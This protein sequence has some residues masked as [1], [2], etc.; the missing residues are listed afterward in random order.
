M[1]FKFRE[2]AE[3]PSDTE[4][5]QPPALFTRAPVVRPLWRSICFTRHDSHGARRKRAQ[6]GLISMSWLIVL[7]AHF[8]GPPGADGLCVHA[9]PRTR[10]AIKSLLWLSAA[11]Q[12]LMNAVGWTFRWNTILRDL[13]FGKVTNYPVVDVQF[14]IK[15]R[16]GSVS[17]NV[18]PVCV[19]HI[20]WQ[21]WFLV[22]CVTANWT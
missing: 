12:V 13:D 5:H 15:T 20:W 9:A 17:P 10:R 6:T 2:C 14:F 3:S 11:R 21:N 19:E 16:G 18:F 8:H 22:S 7:T 4:Q 1:F